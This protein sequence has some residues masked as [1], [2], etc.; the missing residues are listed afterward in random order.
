MQLRVR[1]LSTVA[2][3]R[4]TAV[5][6][7]HGRRRIGEQ[8][9]YGF[10]V[11]PCAVQ[12]L[13]ASGKVAIAKNEDEDEDEDDDEEGEDDKE[14]ACA[15][16]QGLANE[17]ISLQPN[18]KLQDVLR[19]GDRV[20]VH[21]VPGFDTAST[22]A[23]SLGQDGVPKRTEYFTS[24]FGGARAALTKFD[25]EDWLARAERVRKG[26]KKVRRDALEQTLSRRRTA[27]SIA[28]QAE[29][30]AQMSNQG[31]FHNMLQLM[32]DRD[33][34]TEI[35]IAVD[36]DLARTNLDMVLQ[37]LV[38]NSYDRNELISRIRDV[39][40]EYMPALNDIFRYYCGY[41]GSRHCTAKTGFGTATMSR[42]E[43]TSW[44][45]SCGLVD[46]SR[47]SEMLARI[48][49]KTN[50]ETY[51][52]DRIANA[53]NPDGEFLRFEFLEC[54]VRL[55]MELYNGCRSKFETE[56]EP[57]KALKL[58]LDDHI[59]PHLRENLLGEPVRRALQK[60]DVQEMLQ[61]NYAKLLF[62]YQHYASMDMR[63]ATPHARPT[64]SF[65]EFLKLSRDSGL[66]Q[67]ETSLTASS[68]GPTSRQG[69][70]AA[71][72]ES[73]RKPSVLARRLSQRRRSSVNKDPTGLT[74]QDVRLAFAQAQGDQETKIEDLEQLL[75]CEFVEA[76]A[77]VALTKWRNRTEITERDKIKFAVQAI[78]GLVREIKRSEL[79][80]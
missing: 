45:N 33:Q 26:R 31:T 41:S 19:P 46:L 13:R 40:V 77:R 15:D 1:W 44:A 6:C 24:A 29:F 59:I 75:F 37:D 69:V 72:A 2:A 4:F 25:D 43:L 80:R 10:N 14:G 20:L 78:I 21:L 35:E 23:L 5:G 55:S 38:K 12:I 51:S 7:P 32:D 42:L 56:K 50:D 57:D 74:F 68:S 27:R 11:Q 18:Q 53:L 36:Y 8:Q 64:M 54:L 73:Q 34:R 67:P 16:S 30:K 61:T 52:N 3:Q 66:L 47:D 70:P 65:E 9:T 48:F 76:L 79:P 58:M 71:V 60:H 62:V 63:L 22:P 49:V 28:L 39:F 17:L